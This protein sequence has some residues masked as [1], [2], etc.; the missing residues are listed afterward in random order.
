MAGLV[1]E[2]VKQDTI[3]RKTVRV[4]WNFLKTRRIPALLGMHL[5]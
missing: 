5:L 1:F 3:T 2:T 4:V